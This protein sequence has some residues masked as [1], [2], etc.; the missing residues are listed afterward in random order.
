[1]TQNRH[2]ILT[3]NGGWVGLGWTTREMTRG[4]CRRHH[5]TLKHTPAPNN[6]LGAYLEVGKV[7]KMRARMKEEDYTIE[8]RVSQK[9]E[10]K[11]WYATSS[12][13]ARHPA[14]S[15]SACA[16]RRAHLRHAQRTVLLCALRHVRRKRHGRARLA[17]TGLIR[18]LSSPSANNHLIEDWTEKIGV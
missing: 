15:H 3:V 18:H 10:K 6:A 16:H 13:P 8:R 5:T 12:Q 7:R 1:V 4:R 17:F 11:N 14:Q 9:K 2:R